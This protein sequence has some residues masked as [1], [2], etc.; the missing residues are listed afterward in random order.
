MQCAAYVQPNGY[1]DM[2]AKLTNALL[3]SIQ[4]PETGRHVLW[5]TERQGLQFRV[6]NKGARSWLVQKKVKGGE[7]LSITLGRYPDISLSEARAE[8]LRIEMEARSGVNRVK[9]AAASE[10]ARATEAA[11]ARSVGE[12]LELYIDQHIRRNLKEGQS[13]EE[14]ERQLRTSFAPLTQIRM[15]KLTRANLQGIVDN[16]AAEGKITMANRLRSALCAFTA[17]SFNRD[18]IL[19]D[20]GAK[21]QKAGTENARTRTPSISEVREIWSASYDLGDLWGP[22]VRLAILLG[23]RSR[24]EVLEMQW[25]WVN[26]DRRRL[27]I[28]TT[29]NKKPHIVHLPEPAIVEL[30]NLRAHQLNRKLETRFVFTTTG[31]TPASGLSKAKMRLDNILN[32]SRAASDDAP[33]PHWVLHD[34]RRSQATALAEAGFSEAVVDRL[35]NH[36]AVGSRPSQVAHVYQLAEMLDERARALDYWAEI[37]TRQG[38]ENAVPLRA[39]QARGSKREQ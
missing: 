21:V 37:V 7:R 2:K 25:A 6:T 26:F 28:P 1:G 12:V 13:R 11:Q 10:I 34:L 22:Y 31:K 8:A 20:P 24:K 38:S 15:D 14:R 16:K 33:M 9:E 4:P 5:D 36:V 27:E 30:R 19:T 29:K 17:W 35:Q 23:Q 39:E 3:K 32:Q 18:Y